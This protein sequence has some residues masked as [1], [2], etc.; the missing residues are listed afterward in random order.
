MSVVI[1]RVRLIVA[2][3]GLLLACGESRPRDPGASRPADPRD[4]STSDRGPGSDATSGDASFDDGGPSDGGAP[5]DLGVDGGGRDLGPSPDLGTADSGAPDG[6]TPDSGVIR[7]CV[8]TCS[9]PSDC[10][11]PNGGAIADSDNYRCRQGTCEYVGCLGDGECTSVFGAGWVCRAGLVGVATCTRACG[12]V[13]ACVIPASPLYDTDNYRCVSGGCEWTGCNS[14]TECASG[15]NDPRYACTPVPGF[16]FSSCY[17]ACGGPADCVNANAGV[18]FDL[19][20]YD[21][22]AGSCF[23]LGCHSD[24]E[25][26]AQGGSSAWACR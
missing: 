7:S 2:I 22:R 23:Y 12:D 20:N 5:V 4:A 24:A 17:L 10:A 25:C 18:A 11:N 6:G 8:A 19:D 16:S 3:V 14:N 21:C 15:L 26:Q 1:V 13:A 9:S